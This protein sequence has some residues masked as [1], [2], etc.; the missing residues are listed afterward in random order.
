MSKKRLNRR[1]FLKKAANA[2]IGAIGFP[3]IVS[4]S[5]LGKF[6]TVAPS[7]RVT[8]GWIGAGPMGHADISNFLR[9]DDV[10]VT[11]VCDVMTSARQNA[12][13][14]I[15][16]HFQ[17]NVC[18]AYNDF[19][20]L[21][22]RDDIDAVLIATPDHW[23][24]VQAIASAK[25]GKD[26]Y[27]Q[28]PMGLSIAANLA[29]RDAVHRYGVV[30]QFGTQQRSSSHFRRA[31][32]LVRNGR[33]GKLHTIN[34]WCSA[35]DAGGSMEPAAVPEGL[36][37]DMWSG[38]APLKP[39]TD[40]LCFDTPQEEKSWWFISDYCLGWIAGW[41]IHV[42][43]IAQWGTDKELDGIV[44]VE[45]K[46]EYP[47]DGRYDTATSWDVVL[48]YPSGVKI[49]FKGV[50][51]RGIRAREAPPEWQK[52]YGRYGRDGYHG[53]AFEGTDGW[54]LVNREGPKISANP[55]TL[56]NSTI[57]PNEIHLYKSSLHES[58]FIDCVK[59][60]AETICPIDVAV[61]SDN[62]CHISDIAV[63]LGRKLRWDQEKEL[64]INDEQANRMLKRPMQSP[65]HL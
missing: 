16:E 43:D 2:S 23:H 5:A 32:E 17:G 54:I 8:L 41:G 26:I 63:K 12:Q 44:E 42:L 6:G 53:T 47:A 59:S 36:D 3:Y 39:Y 48:K 49:N 35:S 11:A 50:P 10:Q 65:W 56:L 28:K 61:R 34:V 60:R 45:G 38:P 30:F 52:R 20:D 64:F 27:L 1:K 13:N 46:A 31:C 29:L 51:W 18:D 9:R 37:Y 15:N 22:A 14:R 4:S 25:A 62:M 40:S 21:L 24:V 57:G 19:R 58:N 33:V 55:A 7:N